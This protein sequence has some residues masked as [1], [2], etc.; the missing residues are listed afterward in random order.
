MNLIALDNMLKM[1]C[2]WATLIKPV[3]FFINELHCSWCHVKSASYHTAKLNTWRSVD[4]DIILIQSVGVLGKTNN[5][6]KQIEPP[7]ITQLPLLEIQGR[8]LQGL[9][10]AGPV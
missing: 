10:S 5:F 1:K 6:S 9:E 3:T 7:T 2:F 8:C 4:V